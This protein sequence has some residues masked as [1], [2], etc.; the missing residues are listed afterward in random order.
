MAKFDLTATVNTS[1]AGT[2]LAGEQGFTVGVLNGVGATGPAGPTGAG[3]TGGFYDSDYGTV[4]FTSDDGLEFSTGDLRGADGTGSGTVTSVGTGGG[5]GGGPIT[6]SGTIFHAD[7]STQ[8]N[9]DATANTYVDGLTFDDYGHVTYVSTVAGFDGNYSSLAGVPPTFT[10]S[11]HTLSSH[12]DVSTASP[13]DGQ[14]LTWNSSTWEPQTFSG[15]FDGTISGAPPE[16]VFNNTAAAANE[17]GWSVVT[18]AAGDFRIYGADDA[19]DFVNTAQAYIIARTGTNIDSHT[20][21]TSNVDRLQVDDTAIH[22]LDYGGG[23]VTGTA[24]KLLAVDVNGKVVEEDLGNIPQNAPTGAYDLVASDAGGHVSA[25]NNITVDASVFSV[26]DAVSIYNETTGDIT[27]IEGTSVTLRSAGT[28][29]TG[30][31]TL[32]Q[33]GLCTLLCVGTDTFVISGVGLT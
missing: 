31:R 8:A 14:V 25:D 17:K 30:N 27:I 3:F 29:D 9:V 12:S 28:A 22:F 15:G 2:T 32:A 10:P 1:L 6:S 23:T 7:T 24:T 16:L 5:L 20:W 26:G 18:T 11:D 13:T 33:Y 21:K 4:T 19:G